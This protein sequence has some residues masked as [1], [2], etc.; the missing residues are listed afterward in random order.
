MIEKKTFQSNRL[1]ALGA[2]AG[3]FFIIFYAIQDF[4]RPGFNP[5][6]HQVSQLA[7]GD[8]G[9][10]QAI[11]FFIGGLL[12]MVLAAGLYRLT[13]I[14]KLAA[15]LVGFAGLNLFIATFAP[16]DAI[17]G[18]PVG[19]PALPPEIT[20]A[21]LVHKS[22]AGFF[23]LSLLVAGSIYGRYFMK[24]KQR[25]FGIYS[26]LSAVMM[27]V[28]LTFSSI[29]FAQM[30]G[31]VDVAGLFERLSLMSGLLWLTALALYLK[32]KTT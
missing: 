24:H 19:T 31:W 5:L 17:S 6:R 11:N 8:L 23:F 10:L 16:I 29:G 22:V 14:S 1:L 27:I 30:P 13:N 2:L 3:P 21:G 32:G 18:Y 26:I 20:V 12:I 7:L 4:T 15:L 28:F 9:W 25:A